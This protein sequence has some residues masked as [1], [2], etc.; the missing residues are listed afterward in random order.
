MYAVAVKVTLVPEQ[1]FIPGFAAIITA[2]VS[3]VA[4]FKVKGFEV[5]GLPEAQVLDEVIS[6]VTTSPEFKEE[7]EYVELLVPALV[8]FTFHW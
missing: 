4:I 7:E 2:A 3:E 1:T 8:P 5:A 6:H